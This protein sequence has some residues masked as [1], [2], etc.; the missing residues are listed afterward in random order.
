[1]KK[2]LVIDDE[3]D[4]LAILKY[5]LEAEHF[6]VITA[7][8][9][10][11]GMV[12]AMDEHPD[13]IILDVLMHNLDGCSFIQEFK[14]RSGVKSIPVIVLTAMKHLRK[15]FKEEGVENFFEKPFH[16]YEIVNRVK[17]LVGVS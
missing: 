5:S 6:E 12:K 3:Q 1:M 10:I 16:T 7:T 9:G 8:D 4:M 11:E 13:V 17:A 15:N 14:K 2:I